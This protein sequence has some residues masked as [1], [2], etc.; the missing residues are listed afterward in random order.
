MVTEEDNRIVWLFGESGSG[1]SSV[2]YTLAK[3]LSAQDK[4]AATF[5]FSRTHADRSDTSLVFLTLAYQIGL[6]HPRA[7]DIIAKAINNDPEL[8]SSAKCRSD[9]FEHLVKAPLKSL[10]LVWETP[11]KIVLDAIDEGVTSDR[12]SL[13]P[14]IL[15]MNDL[16]HDPSIPISHVLVTSRPSPLLDT[17]L[18]R[19]TAEG[20]VQSLNIQHFDSHHDVELFLRHSFD[21]IYDMRD[22]SFLHEKPWPS[23]RVISSLSCRIK[24]RFIVAATVV[25]LISKSESPGDCL[26]L[27]SKMYDG[28]VDTVDLDLGDIDSIYRY[29]LSS[30]EEHN[31][32]SGVEHLSD[33]MVLAKPLTLP[34][35]CALS[36]VDISKHI[37]HLSAIVVL[38]P[39]YSLM[40][41]QVYHSSLQDYLWDK[42]RSGDFHVSPLS[43]HD[44]L[45]GW[46]FQLIKRKLKGDETK[47][48][49]V[50]DAKQ[51]KT[52]LRY[53]M[54]YWCYHLQRSEPS[55]RVR[56]LTHDFVKNRAVLFL[57]TAAAL[58]Q[59]AEAMY[60]LIHAWFVI[61]RW[62]PFLNQ[63]EI[64]AG[65]EV[66]WRAYNHYLAERSR[67]PGGSS[68]GPTRAR[69]GS[70]GTKHV[71]A[72]VELE[73]GGQTAAHSQPPSAGIMPT[74]DLTMLPE[75]SSWPY[76][77]SF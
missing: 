26:D 43:S 2:A 38:P 39:M 71:S 41:V 70:T 52:P 30:C 48:Q 59:F 8:L 10:R 21:E 62:K 35:I 65:L 51:I 61:S 42:S 74:A 68:K 44:R 77:R 72:V 47:V 49:A 6:L 40:T 53:A 14:L 4:L 24:G 18:R 13:E 31:Q 16:I 11:R 36:G 45:A 37:V 32:R 64:L 9:Q 33:I 5:F 3:Q 27:I 69:S 55:R 29:V 67:A 60:C 76:F 58:G 19:L 12:A 54:S 7:K 20:S 73:T 17:L 25:R 15:A 75:V 46:C 50:E 57:E 23:S 28:N 63:D 66:H 34:D 22:I 56:A 1:K